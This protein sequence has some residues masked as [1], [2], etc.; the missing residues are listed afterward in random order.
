MSQALET[1]ALGEWRV[2]FTM[3]AGEA[4]RVFVMSIPAVDE[5]HALHGAH[6]IALGINEATGYV[7]KL[8]SEF[9][10][11]VAA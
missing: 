7:W 2:T 1:A 11:E 4:R 3:H 8:T 5:E 6:Q 10:A 9:A